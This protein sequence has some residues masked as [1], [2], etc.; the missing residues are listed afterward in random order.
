MTELLRTHEKGSA[1]LKSRI[2]LGRPAAVAHGRCPRPRTLAAVPMLLLAACAQQQAIRPPL[3]SGQASGS[4]VSDRPADAPTAAFPVAMRGLWAASPQA[5]QGPHEG[6]GWIRIGADRL[7]G[8]E[9]S[10]RPL[11]ARP[12]GAGRW[13]I[14]SE[15]NYL[16]TQ[17]AEV[18]QILALGRDT[19]AIEEGPRVD[20]YV[21]CGE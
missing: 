7:S 19:L 20:R 17:F 2:G 14:R 10:L 11:E 18:V 9:V 6:E 3:A 4:H 5:C 15:E 8:Y 13:R 16:G 21:R 1:A 12:L